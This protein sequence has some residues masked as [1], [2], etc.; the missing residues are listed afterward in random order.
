MN[1]T[2]EEAGPCRKKL[3]IE[4]PADKVTAEYEELV[5]LFTKS[6]RIP[7]F[8][9]GKAPKN[10][11]EKRF[12][13]D[14]DEELRSRLIST[15]YH[16]A[17]KNE[18]LNP[19]AVLSVDDSELKTGENL[20]VDI[21]LDVPPEF[22]LPEY[23]GIKVEGKNSVV[24]DEDVEEALNQLRER[25]ASY[26]DVSDRAVAK[27]DLV[28]IDY[29]GACDGQKIDELAVDAEGLGSGKD[30][31]VMA[32]E[33]AFL[34][35]FG[36]ALVGT[37]AGDKKDI[38]VDFASDFAVAAVAG[39]KAV[40]QVEVKGVREKHL[41]EI[42]EEFLKGYQVQS[43]E[44]L[45]DRIR[46]DLLRMKENEEKNRQREELIKH[47]MERVTMD[48]PES[49]V[50]QE[51]RN[52]IYDMVRNNTARGLSKEKIEEQKDEIY[53]AASTTAAERVKL[54]YILHKIAE[55]EKIT[56]SANEV[57]SEIQM[58]AMRYG[59][60]PDDL[61]KDIK[62]KDAMDS[63]KEDITNRKTVDFLLEQAEVS[64]G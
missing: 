39:K 22:S 9:A 26:E 14:I 5:K 29:V 35:G 56:A 18:N 42:D 59:M 45:D 32:D 44:E 23:K 64:A 63:I 34:P 3:H 6:A 11:V 12:A 24:N 51:T 8:R 57:T 58:M 38:M 54:R 16:D 1:V 10:L 28:Q 15:S 47:L 53:N 52:T 40:Y 48:L 31:W 46:E 17:L 21:M 50:S 2:V 25:G 36:E 30:F 7:G 13:K 43:K 62:K 41:P 20:T 27:G 4:V 49:V 55:E 37:K 61:M 33:N 60:R 19:V